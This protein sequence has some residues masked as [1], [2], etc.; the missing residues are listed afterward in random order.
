MSYLC[1]EGMQSKLVL[2]LKNIYKIF[3]FAVGIKLCVCVCVCREWNDKKR[4]R[5]KILEEADLENICW[6]RE[7]F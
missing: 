7:V 5:M 2:I 6:G 3:A 1:T 4:R